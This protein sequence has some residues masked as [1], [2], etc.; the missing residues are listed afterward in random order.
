MSLGTYDMIATAS[1]GVAGAALVIAWYG[2][3][4]ANKTTSAA[5]LIALNEG[6][7]QGWERY[8]DANKK[9]EDSRITI[10]LAELLNLFEIACSS[11]FEKS[12]SGNSRE[13]L[14][15]YLDSTLESLVKYPDT[16]ERVTEKLIQSKTTFKYIKKYV[17]KLIDRQMKAKENS[18][19]PIEQEPTILSVTV[20]P[21]WY[22]L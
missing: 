21:G 9:A 16:A 17:K 18:G 11:Y 3:L 4:R 10:E 6:L 14:E 5:T 1:L 13:L 7:R 2:I 19:E 15:E 20:P 12:F 8:F 22:R